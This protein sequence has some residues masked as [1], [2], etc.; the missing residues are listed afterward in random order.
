M[1]TSIEDVIKRFGDLNYITNRTIAT[2]VYLAS[3]MKK[4]ILVEGPAGVGKTELA[5]VLALALDQELI[6]LQ[7]YEGLDEAKALYEWEYAKQLLYTQILKDKISEVL[8]GARSLRE[9][10]D[11][12]ANEDDVFFS[13]RFILPRP[14]MR[15][16]TSETPSVLLID[17]IDKSDTEFEA[18]LLEILSDFQVSVPELGTLKARHVPLVVLTSNNAREM[19]D[20]LKRRCLHLFIDF[21]SREHELEIVRLKIPGV[22]EALAAD[23]VAVVQRIRQLDLKKAPSIS[24]TL[25]W[26]RAL[27]LLNVKALDEAV[28]A[29]TLSTILKY[30]GDIRKAQA[31]LKD[32]VEKQR[33]KLQAAP[34]ERNKD[35]LH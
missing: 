34:A 26:T 31:E 11:R 21:P 17:E 3:E 29:E 4:P 5:K 12:I 18:F 30:E 1:F 19:S 22:S 13:D 10:V 25:D 33:V 6:R 8:G 7:C 9:A 27:T 32:Y 35:V 23:V 16:I 28:V 15:A 24:E 20:A 14:L 2:V